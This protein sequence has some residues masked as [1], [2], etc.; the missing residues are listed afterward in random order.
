M[1]KHSQVRESATIFGSRVVCGCSVSSARAA[2]R[3]AALAGSHAHLVG[4]QARP[5]SFFL[6]GLLRVQVSSS[7][8]TRLRILH[9][10]LQPTHPRRPGGRRRGQCIGTD[11]SSVAKRGLSVARRHADPWHA[12][13]AVGEDLCGGRVTAKSRA[14]RSPPAV[15]SRPRSPARPPRTCW[16]TPTPRPGCWQSATR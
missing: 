5:A 9:S 15:R 4:R 16:T 13:A 7:F 6:D 2:S 3:A 8:S 14:A 11:N 10:P 1:Q 12:S